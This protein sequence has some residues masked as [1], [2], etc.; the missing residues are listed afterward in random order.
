MVTV[1]GVMKV[2]YS[3]KNVGVKSRVDPNIRIAYAH[4]HPQNDIAT[5]L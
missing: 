5:V 4:L 1:F 2:D 3:I